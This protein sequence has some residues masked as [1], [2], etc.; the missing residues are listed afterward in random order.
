MN[1]FMTASVAFTML[2][3]VL[4]MAAVV[5]LYADA[6]TSGTDPFSG[7]GDQTSSIS[8]IAK[9]NLGKFAFFVAL[10][11][12]GFCVVFTTKH[13][14]FGLF[15][16]GFGFFLGVYSG[17]ANSLWTWFTSIGGN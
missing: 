16:L 12:G 2:V 7:M 6:A 9:G 15:A 4:L 3:I 13:R 14:V 1:K 17:I 11:V 5:P 8:A 10:L